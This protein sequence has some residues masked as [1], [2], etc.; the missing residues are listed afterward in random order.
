ML[1][2]WL[3]IFL[4]QFASNGEVTIPRLF[5]NF[6]VWGTK[7]CPM[8]ARDRFNCPRE[9]SSIFRTIQHQTK[10]PTNQE[11]PRNILHSHI[12]H[13]V[14]STFQEK[15]LQPTQ[16]PHVT[17]A[18]VGDSPPLW[19]VTSLANTVVADDLGTTSSPS[20]HAGLWGLAKAIS[21]SEKCDPD[22]PRP[23]DQNS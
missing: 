23:L 15:S 22:I 10:S 20:N 9:K 18:Q 7:P 6:I 11:N 12:V 13:H 17:I 5:Q 8:P 19:M 2:A 3:L 14:P 4:C 21:P 16:L 1:P